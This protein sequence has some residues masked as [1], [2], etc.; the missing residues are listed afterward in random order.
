MDFIHEPY[1][2]G[3][4]IAAIATA[5]GDGGVAIIRVSGDKALEVVSKIYSDDLYTYKSHTAHF[6]KI[7]DEYKNHIDDVLLL[8]FKGTKSFTGENTVEIHC[9][10]GHLLT[11]KILKLVIQAGARLA[12]PG[13]FSF[14]A[15]INGKIDLTQ[16]ESIQALISAKNER[17]VKAASQHLNGGLSTKI[18]LFQKKI[19]HI[20][21][22]LEA[23]VDFP[24]EGLE[25][26]SMDEICDSLKIII[27]EMDQLLNTYSDGKIIHEGLSLCLVGTPNVGKSSLMNALLDKDRAI[28]SPIPGTTRD[29]IEDNLRING[30]NFRLIDTAG[31]RQTDEVIESQGIIRTKQTIEEADLI[32]LIMDASRSLE[33]EDKNLLEEIPFEKTILIWN[34]VDISHESIT[35]F[36]RFKNIC[37]LSAKTKEGID[38]LK[39]TIDNVIWTN[40]NHHEE[41]MLTNARHFEALQQAKLFLEAVLEG[42]R[43]NVSP[44]F[45]SQDIR[46]ALK[47]LGKIIGT[48]ISEDILS[49]I[50]STFCI[51]K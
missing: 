7:I 15:F 43:S 33:V 8:V 20:A 27:H 2:A 36:E 6:G 5:P 26:A 3:E 46:F 44:E 31:V 39:K 19:T 18:N 16:A 50:F 29:V 11:K 17:A 25:F 12:R 1:Q 13:E 42:L 49:E 30:M 38:Q 9:H 28:V 48:N 10:G 51:G 23:W 14:K 37:L 47:E 34:K 21:A 41:I 24:E 4:T 22:I 32:L 45:V 35:L 40:Q